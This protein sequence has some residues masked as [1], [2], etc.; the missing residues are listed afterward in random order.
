[1]V[2]KETLWPCKPRTKSKLKI[3]S[4]YL[5]A[6]FGILAKNGFKHVI[7]IDGFCGPGEYTTREEGSP[8]IAARIANSTAQKSPGF[9]ATLFFVDK[10]SKVLQHLKSTNAIKNLH[11]NVDVQ[12][13]EGVFAQEIDS[14]LLYLKKNPKS[15]T[16]SFIDPRGFGQSPFEKLKPLMHNESSELFINFMCG[17]MNRFKEHKDEKVIQKIKEMVGSDDLTAIIN[18]NDP[19]DKLCEVYE[20]KLKSLGE[21]TFKVSMRDEGNV[22]DNTFFFC[23][24]QLLGF[25]KI[26]EAMWKID[27]EHGNSFSAHGELKKSAPQKDFFDEPEPQTSK[28]SSLLIQHYAGEKDVPIEDI[29][30]WVTEETA[31]LPT[32]ARMELENL[33]ERGQITYRDP[34]N[35]GRKRRRN[36]WADGWLISFKERPPP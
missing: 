21:Y 36:T 22:R 35:I 14:I 33:C 32:H 23:G 10:N 28:L 2:K 9:K 6:W 5:G 3:V 30:R 13:K 7:Y 4:N 18:A 29:F 19:I 1:M 25:Q 16:F 27:P 11:P 12:I 20:T 31:F 34:S 17:F 26:K 24:R 15:P 8:V